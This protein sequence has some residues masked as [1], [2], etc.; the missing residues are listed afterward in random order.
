LRELDQ[1]LLWL[2]ADV[3][4]FHQ[5]GDRGVL[6]FLWDRWKNTETSEPL[7]SFTI[8]VTDANALTQPIHHRAPVTLDKADVRL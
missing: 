2:N 7:I 8:I 4:L 3:R 5:R 6:S 1:R